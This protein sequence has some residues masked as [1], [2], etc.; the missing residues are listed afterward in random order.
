V[1][2]RNRIPK[3]AL[4]TRPFAL[5]A[6]VALDLLCGIAYHL[7]LNLTAKGLHSMGNT[8]SRNAKF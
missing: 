5:D 6:D 1:E 2:K 8:M 7:G 4:A 3:K